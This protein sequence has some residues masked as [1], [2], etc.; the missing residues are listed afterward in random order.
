MHL[1]RLNA[2]LKAIEKTP[3]KWDQN[4][5]HCGTTSCIAGWAQVASGVRACSTS[6]ARDAM[7]WL[8][9]TLVEANWLFNHQRTLE[10]FL[11]VGA[12]NPVFNEDGYDRHGFNAKGFNANGTLALT[13]Y[14][15]MEIE[16]YFQP[17]YVNVAYPDISKQR[18]RT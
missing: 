15:D 14:E 6:T 1:P 18:E 3:D 4:H 10:D 13:G 8:D 12:G 16:A 11:Y 17:P 5:W 9:L 2:I 7:A